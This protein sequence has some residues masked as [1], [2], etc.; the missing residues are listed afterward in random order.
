M[1]K[2]RINKLLVGLLFPMPDFH[3]ADFDDLVS[4]TETGGF[5]IQID[6]ALQIVPL[7]FMK[8]T[9]VPLPKR[10]FLL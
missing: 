5:K 8:G 3:G 2:G 9:C 6:Y 10:S 4:F 1:F 7:P